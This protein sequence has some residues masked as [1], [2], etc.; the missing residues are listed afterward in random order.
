MALPTSPPPEP[1]L[2]AEPSPVGDLLRAVLTAAAAHG[3]S[4]VHLRSGSPPILRISGELTDLDMPALTDDQARALADQALGSA[5]DREA[6][7]GDHERDFALSVPG[8]G[9]FRGNAYLNRGVPAMVLRHIRESVPSWEWLHA[10]G[11]LRDL[12]LR[13][14]GLVL[15]TG[16][17]GSGKS[18]TLAAMV[19][20]INDRRRCHILTIEDPIEF[21]HADRMA[22]VSQR[23]IVTDTQS[24]S[25]AL[26]SGMRQDPDVIVVGEVRDVDT[27]RTMLRA[28]ETGH[29]VLASLHARTVVDAVN[30]VI[31]LYPQEEQRQAAISLSEVLLAVVCQRLVPALREGER[32]LVTEVAV[33]T[34]RIQ[35]A[36]REPEKVSAIADVMA[37]GEYYGMYTLEQDAVRQVLAGEISVESAERAVTHVADLH[38]AL[39]KAG[40]SDDRLR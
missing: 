17:T 18:T 11:I 9:R 33:A 27:V 16:P 32:R 2:R 22:T 21:L 4:D 5:R 1:A 13:P 12:A 20:E 34:P 25:R 28:A 30:R 24:F 39:R 26:R 31:D 6:F 29:L 36:V 8:A 23:E 37:D 7:A 35:E 14:D 40:V 38:V 15:V 10:P 3:A 19:Q